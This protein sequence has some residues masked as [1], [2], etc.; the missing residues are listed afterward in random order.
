MRSTRQREA[1]FEEYKRTFDKAYESDEDHNNRHL[2][3]HWNLRY[4]HAFN[5]QVRATTRYRTNARRRLPD[6]SAT[7]LVKQMEPNHVP[8]LRAR[9]PSKSRTGESWLSSSH[10]SSSP[11]PFFHVSRVHV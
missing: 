6:L 8:C 5:R 7:V 3:F 11:K 4:I 9:E 2:V 1:A 10:F